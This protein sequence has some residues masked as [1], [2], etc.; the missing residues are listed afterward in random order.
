MF[1]IG[2][3]KIFICPPELDLVVDKND[4]TPEEI[5]DAAAQVDLFSC[6]PER[7]YAA[8]VTQSMHRNMTVLSDAV[9]SNR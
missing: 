6:S 8:T 5:H 3:D 9:V 4:I 2:R 1:E 7:Y